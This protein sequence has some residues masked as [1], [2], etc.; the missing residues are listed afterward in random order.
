M[1]QRRTPRTIAQKLK[2]IFWPSMG[3]MRLAVYYRHR[4]GRLPG[5][6]HFIAAGFATGVAVSFTPFMGFHLLLVAIACFIFRMSLISSIIGTVFA[7]NPWTFPFIWVGTYKLGE[8]MLGRGMPQEDIPVFTLRHLMD[9]PLDLIVPM[10]VG[11]LPIL[12]LSWLLS[13]YIARHVVNRYR[14]T[15]AAKMYRDTFF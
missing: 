6:T 1:F 3:L 7:G 4:M 11:C 8:W 10:T 2:E 5:T 14:G 13:F 12:P 15:R 9:K